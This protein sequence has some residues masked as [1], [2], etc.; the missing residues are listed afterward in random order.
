MEI[1]IVN[2]LPLETPYQV[3]KMKKQIKDS[4]LYYDVEANETCPNSDLYIL[5]VDKNF[6]EAET[7]L[8]KNKI[9]KR[10]AICFSS[11]HHKGWTC[12]CMPKAF[13]KE[14]DGEKMMQYLGCIMMERSVDDLKHSFDLKCIRVHK[15]TSLKEGSEKILKNMNSKRKIVL[16]YFVKEKTRKM[17]DT[18]GADEHVHQH[19]IRGVDSEMEVLICKRKS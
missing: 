13:E 5:I 14:F 11:V 8:Q 15:E 4:K 6:Q 17:M 18:D 19:W 12:W 1:Q 9:E 16:H 7:W 3:T 10:K 2:M